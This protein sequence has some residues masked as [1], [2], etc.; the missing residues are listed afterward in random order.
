MKIATLWYLLIFTISFTTLYGCKNDN[1]KPAVPVPVRDIDGNTYK[2]ITIGN[3][4][5]LAENLNVTHYRNGD[6]IL[7]S[8]TNL[9]T[10]AYCNYNNDPAMGDIYGKLYNNA[11]IHDSR[12]VCPAG[13]HL[14]TDAEWH[15]LATALGGDNAAGGAL[16][17]SG[18]AHWNNPNTGA[19]NSSNFNALP[20]G[21]NGSGTFVDMGNATYFWSNPGDTYTRALNTANL[22]LMGTSN[23]YHNQFLS[24]RCVK[25]K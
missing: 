8:S 12:N 11:V 5:W 18:N 16:K 20:A 24:I 17:E 9:D 13:W 1:P 3:D 15:D 19:S 4:T 14:P 23:T 25:D 2:T 22:E 7:A 21:N 10:G 6:A